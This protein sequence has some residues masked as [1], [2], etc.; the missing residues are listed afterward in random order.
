MVPLIPRTNDVIKESILSNMNEIENL[1]EEAF[2]VGKGLNDAEIAA[3][4]KLFQK[5]PAQRHSQRYGQWATV[6]RRE[7][8]YLFFV[9]ILFVLF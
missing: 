5:R 7:V 9:L 2:K 3:V 8:L 6:I 1:M 4:Y